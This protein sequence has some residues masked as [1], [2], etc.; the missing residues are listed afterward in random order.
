MSRLFSEKYLADRPARPPAALLFATWQ[1]AAERQLLPM[2]ICLSAAHA[3]L[4]HTCFGQSRAFVPLIK[5]WDGGSFIEWRWGSMVAVTEALLERRKALQQCWCARKFSFRMPEGPQLQSRQPDEA[6]ADVPDPEN[7]VRTASHGADAAF[8]KQVDAAVQS[9]LF[10]AYASMVQLLAG[11]LDRLSNWAEGCQCHEWG[12]RKPRAAAL[13]TRGWSRRQSHQTQR[14]SARLGQ[15]HTGGDKRPNSSDSDISVC[16]FRGRRAPE[17]AAGFFQ[18]ATEYMARACTSEVLA[19]TS[20][21]EPGHR[22]IVATDWSAASDAALSVLQTRTAHWNTLPYLLCALAVPD[23]DESRSAGRRALEL[24]H[25]TG[26]SGNHHRMT[27]RFLDPG[28]EPDK[29]VPGDIPLY[30]QLVDY[31]HGADLSD[32][33]QLQT[34]IGALRLIRVVERQTEARHAP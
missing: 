28:F 30:E 5:S 32:L 25:R 26:A 4:V 15:R 11:F 23:E 7:A 31:L 21:L 2:S 14:L 8:I 16:L 1:L 17:L 27:R 10:W 9:K 24:F 29:S 19:L 12:Y 6:S 18:R 34:W 20:G 3:R 22:S 13:A 33:P